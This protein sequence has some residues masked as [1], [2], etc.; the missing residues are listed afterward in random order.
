MPFQMV[1]RQLHQGGPVLVRMLPGLSF[2]KLLLFSYY[3]TPG[4]FFSGAPKPT[5]EVPPSQLFHPQIPDKHYYMDSPSCSSLLFFIR[6]LRPYME[7]MASD[8]YKTAITRFAI[9]SLYHPAKA[10]W[11]THNPEFRLE[12]VALFSFF[13]THFLIT[14]YFANR[15]Q[16]L[17][18]I[19][20]L[21]T[22]YHAKNL[23][24]KGFFDTESET[25]QKHA[26]QYSTDHIR[27]NKLW[28]KALQNAT[29]TRNFSELTSTLMEEMHVSAYEPTANKFRFDMIPYGKNNADTQTFSTPDRDTPL[30]SFSLNFTYNNLSGN[31]GDYIDRQDNKSAPLRHARQMF[32]C[33]YIPGTK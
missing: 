10:F 8:F 11:T 22:L 21:L 9:Q 6:S 26:D 4:R 12:L 17:V 3:T 5:W 18:D 23:E 14:C 33:A 19:K 13:F 32:S 29:E 24:D 30:R 25:M 2:N 31:W 20:N 16:S 15:F 28:Q 1:Q 27:L 7:K